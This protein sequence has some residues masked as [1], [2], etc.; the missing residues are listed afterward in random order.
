MDTKEL[1]QEVGDGFNVF[2]VT[3]LRHRLDDMMGEM[4]ELM[5][6]HNIQN[7]KEE[8]GDL[9]ASAIQLANESGWDF[10]DLVQATL[11]KIERRRT[12][13]VSL[14]RK[15][16]VAVLGGAFDPIH[17]GHIQTALLV[18][19]SSLIFDEVL[20]LPDFSH[21]NNKKMEP[22]EHRLAMCEL[23]AQVDYRIRVSGYAIANQLA[24]E[25][26]HY[27]QKVLAEDFAKDQIDIS[28][29]LGLDNANTFT[30]WP[31][32]EYLEKMMRFVIVARQGYQPKT[33]DWYTNPPHIFLADE[34][35][36]IM[37]ISSTLARRMLAEGDENISQILDS[38][39]LEYIKKNGLYGVALS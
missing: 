14:G 11:V 25:T 1:Q 28:V 3:P 22:P 17:L 33:G 4:L 36:Q 24:G 10:A 2:G 26:Y 9:L 19:D 12:Q 15:K 37:D 39:V 13:Y 32:Y 29:V 8:L 7:I 21:M 30:S 23:A 38:A 31:N 27:V 35:K 34:S 18:L 6:Y 20:L 5:R 16:K